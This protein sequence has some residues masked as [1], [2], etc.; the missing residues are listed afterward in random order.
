MYFTID[1]YE[2]EHVNEI[3]NDIF[4]RLNC[5]MLDV[6]D[7]LVGMDS[8]VNEIIRKLCIDQLNDVRIIGICGIG[9]MGKTTIAKLVYNTFFS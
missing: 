6:G 1:R 8:H 7:N 4:K 3:I 2:S 9:G 5:K